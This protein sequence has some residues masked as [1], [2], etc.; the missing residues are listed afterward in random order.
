MNTLQSIPIDTLHEIFKYLSFTDLLNIY[1]L[2]N[3]NIN[4]AFN[5]RD[6][7]KIDFRNDNNDV[8]L[9][10]FPEYKQLYSTQNRIYDVFDQLIKMKYIDFRHI[11]FNQQLGS[12]LHSLTSLQT[13]DFGD[14]FNNGDQ[15]LGT[16]LQGLTNLETITF[17]NN[18]NQPLGTSLQGL[19]NLQTINFGGSF[20][21]GNQPSDISLEGLPKLE[22]INFET[23]FIGESLLD[24]SL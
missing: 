4:E 12:S 6:G 9:N 15:P 5:G 20:N 3:K 14:D 18:F 10:R 8:Y 17:G 24:L 21:N 11:N 2:H 13:I 23:D 22:N 1:S 7:I 16:S 19:T